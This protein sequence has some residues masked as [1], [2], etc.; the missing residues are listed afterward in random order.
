MNA[1]SPENLSDGMRMAAA[2]RTQPRTN[3]SLSC[4]LFPSHIIAPGPDQQHEVAVEK[5]RAAAPNPVTLEG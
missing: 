5:S 2:E 3:F 4:F 1:E